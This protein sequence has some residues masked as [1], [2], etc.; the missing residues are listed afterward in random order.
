MVEMADTF[1]SSA[2][3]LKRILG[4]VEENASSVGNGKVS[5]TRRAGSNGDGHIKDEKALARFGLAA[6]NPDGLVGP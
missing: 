4:G 5:K 6:D 1:E 2:H 3:H